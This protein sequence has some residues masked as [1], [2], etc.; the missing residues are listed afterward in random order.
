MRWARDAMDA[1]QA[2]GD[3]APDETPGRVRRSRVV[4]APR[5][6]RQVGGTIRRRRW[7]KRPL[8]GES[9]KET[10]KP[11]RGESR[12]V[13]AVPVVLP[14]CAFFFAHGLRAQ[15]APGFPCALSSEQRDNATANPGQNQA[16]AMPTLARPRKRCSLA[17]ARGLDLNQADPA[18]AAEFC[19]DRHGGTACEPSDSSSPARTKSSLPSGSRCWRCWSI[20]PSS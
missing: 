18:S 9:T 20:G 13:S 1:G 8:T 4:L 3:L 11:L 15:S 2:S 6:W 5:P 17:L 16:A 7:Q 14:P 19:A 10:V 12:D